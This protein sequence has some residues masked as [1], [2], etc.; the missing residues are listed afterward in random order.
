M[1]LSETKLLILLASTILGFLLASQINFGNLSLREVLTLEDYQKVS[2][3]IYKIT[4][5][6]NTLAQEEKALEDKL[7]EYRLSGNSSVQSIDKLGEDLN[8]YDIYAGTTD[9]KGPGVV[10]SLSDSELSSETDSREVFFEQSY[11]VHDFDLL[12]LVWDL[13]NAGAEAISVNGQRII[14]NTE[15]Y[16]G[17]TVIYINGTMQLPPY[18]I[19]AIGD[20][21]NIA[22]YLKDEN[23]VYNEFVGRAL[24][25]SFKKE[26]EVKIPRYEGEIDRPHVS[27]AEQ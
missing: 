9:I 21:D 5:E 23:S 25:V 6:L 26:N 14:Y 13:K 20:P 10:I 18:T 27:P 7:R 16:C 24:N 11:L 8:E 3:E 12:R 22:S 15:L 1:K 17:G 4:G 2:S 19:K